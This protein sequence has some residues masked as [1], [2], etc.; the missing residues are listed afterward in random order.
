MIAAEAAKRDLLQK[1]FPVLFNRHF[2]HVRREPARSNGIDL[3]V[4]N[5]PLAGQILGES[6]DATL[7][8]VIADGLKLRRGASHS[9]HRGDVNDFPPPLR[10]H[11]FSSGL[12]EKECAGEVRLDHL[13]PMLQFHLLDGSAPGRTRIVDENVDAAEFRDCFL[14]NIANVLWIL[15]VARKSQSLD[16]KLL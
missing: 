12:R 3:D 4:V 10:K 16:A 5:A 15:D 14:N 11:E 1:G 13:V 8:G 6:D 7:A 2:G 9:R